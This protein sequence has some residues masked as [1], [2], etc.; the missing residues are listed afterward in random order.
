M[1]SAQL[2]WPACLQLRDKAEQNECPRSGGQAIALDC[3]WI[4]QLQGHLLV[5]LIPLA[6][7]RRADQ[8]Q[9]LAVGAI[10]VGVVKDRVAVPPGCKVAALQFLQYVQRQSGIAA[11]ALLR[12]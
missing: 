5:E 11:L 12:A 10:L 3:F 1:A 4:A 7:T 8:L 2:L 9:R 6:R